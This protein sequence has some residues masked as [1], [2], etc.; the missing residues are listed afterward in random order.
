MTFELAGYGHT[1][2]T[3][4]RGAELLGVL[5]EEASDGVEQVCIDF[6][7]VQHVSYSFADEFVGGL[8]ERAEIG[9]CGFEVSLVHVP[10]KVQRLIDASAR[11]RGIA[12]TPRVVA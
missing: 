9:A 12:V 8:L 5:L 11:T 2:S 1:F 4:P 3:R 6:A 7:N 10:S